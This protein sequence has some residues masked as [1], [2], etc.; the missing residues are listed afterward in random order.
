MT[1]IRYNSPYTPPW[2]SPAL[3]HSS[4]Q[5]C[6]TELQK[7]RQ[8]TEKDTIFLP[9]LSSTASFAWLAGSQGIFMAPSREVRVDL[10]SYPKTASL[11]A[12]LGPHSLNGLKLL[13]QHQ[14]IPLIMMI[15]SE[16]PSSNYHLSPWL[17][18]LYPRP[19]TS[20]SNQEKRVHAYHQRG[21]G[22]FQV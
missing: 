6:L 15:G 12:T 21:T 2:V 14:K 4:W 8:G 7:N 9:F 3:E 16:V 11:D 5:V 19:V 22:N 10:S 18:R 13:I 20:P 1:I 17:P